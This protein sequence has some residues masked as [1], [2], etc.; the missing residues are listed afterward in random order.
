MEYDGA[1]INDHEPKTAFY[2]P[3]PYSLLGARPRP[4]RA[5][6]DG[7]KNGRPRKECAGAPG[8][9]RLRTPAGN[10][11]GRPRHEPFRQPRHFRGSRK[12][13]DYVGEHPGSLPVVSRGGEVG[14]GAP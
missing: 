11:R 12:K 8:L 4:D 13:M 14:Q 1:R 2:N 6:N 3:A 5:R 9:S 7:P 10:S